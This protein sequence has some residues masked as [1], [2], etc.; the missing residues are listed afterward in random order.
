MILHEIPTRL[1]VD[2]RCKGQHVQ[3][4]IR[5]DDQAAGTKRERLAHLRARG[6][7]LE[8]EMP[9]SRRR[10]TAEFMARAKGDR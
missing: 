5:N 1:A 3:C 9:D 4:T 10:I 2:Q 6:H 7:V 8:A